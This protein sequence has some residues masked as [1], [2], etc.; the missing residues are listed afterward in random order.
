MNTLGQKVKSVTVQELFTL[1][2][3]S[4]LKTQ[5]GFPLLAQRN[6]SE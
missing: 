1:T 2:P 5:A 3:T 6:F 4:W